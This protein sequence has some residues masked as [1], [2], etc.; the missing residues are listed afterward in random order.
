MRA[1][2]I[3]LIGFALLI[4]LLGSAGADDAG[5]ADSVDEPTK[6]NPVIFWELASHDAEASVAFFEK[7][8][9]WDIE[10]IPNTIIHGVDSRSED[11]GITGGIFT[12]QKAKLPFLT[13]FIQV[14]DIQE[15]AKLVKEH[16]GLITE[17]PK[18]ISSGSWICL[19][20]DPSGVTFAMLQRATPTE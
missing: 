20:N 9:D 3:I 14:D 10:L 12:L 16:G 13:I 8:F 18:Q 2:Q 17:E 11:R 6:A 15:K 1:A 19:F 4:A 5:T 7:L